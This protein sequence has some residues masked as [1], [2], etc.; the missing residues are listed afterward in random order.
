MTV[1][2]KMPVRRTSPTRSENGN[3]YRKHKPDLREDFN[4]HCGYCGSYDSFGYSRTYFEIDHFVPKDFLLRTRSSIGLSKYSNLVYSC[5]F[6]NNYKTQHWPSQRDDVYIKGDTGFIDP[7][8]P[9]YEKH[10]YRTDEGAIMWNTP[11]GKWL[12][13]VAFRF[14][15]RSEEIKMLWK[16]NS[17]RLT[18]DKILDELSM[19]QTESPDYLDRKS[20]LT[21]LFQ[22]NYIIQK[23]LA[24][25]YNG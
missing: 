19:Y 21:N 23:E 10:L 6:C 5:K 3:N 9:D 13:T 12:V 2:E 7:C 14:D 16:L 20:Q 17:I 1:R 18:I 15:E 22:T 4:Q 25:Y 24:N 8:D 11:I